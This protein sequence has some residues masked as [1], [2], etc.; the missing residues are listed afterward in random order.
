[1]ILS[2]LRYS[3]PRL[4]VSNRRTSFLCSEIP[5]CAI[6]FPCRAARRSSVAHLGL[7]CYSFAPTCDSFP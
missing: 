5:F 6:P 1:M 7:H 4:R 3:S 2:L